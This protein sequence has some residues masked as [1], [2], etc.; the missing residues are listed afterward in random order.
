MKKFLPNTVGVVLFFSLFLSPVVQAQNFLINDIHAQEGILMRGMVSSSPESLYENPPIDPSPIDFFKEQISKDMLLSMYE[1]SGLCNSNVPFIVVDFSDDPGGTFHLS[2]DFRN[3]YCCG[4]SGGGNRCF[5]VLLI[6]SDQTAA[7]SIK[8]SGAPATGA[9]NWWLTPLPAQSGQCALPSY[10]IG[11]QACIAEGGIYAL[12]FCKPGQNT[13]N[14]IIEAIPYPQIEE[15]YEVRQDCSVQLNA[16]GFVDSSVTW[17]G[18]YLSALD[19]STGILTPTFTWSPGLPLYPDYIEYTICGT[20]LA[21]DECINQIGE[22]CATTRIYVYPE[23]EAG[24]TPVEPLFCEGGSILVEALASGGKP[25]YM[26]SW[27]NPLGQVVSSE[28]SINVSDAGEYTLVVSDQLTGAGCPAFEFDFVIEQVSLSLSA[29]VEA[30]SCFDGNDGSINVSVSGG[31]EPFQYIWS[32]DP[33]LNGPVASHLSAGQYSLTVTDANGCEAMILF[34]VGQPDSALDATISQIEHESCFGANDGAVGI[35]VEGGTPPYI[36]YITDEFGQTVSFDDQAVNQKTAGRNTLFGN[37]SSLER[38]KAKVLLM[39]GQFTAS[40]LAPGTYTVNVFDANA[41][42][43]EFTF[44]IEPGEQIIVSISADGDN[45]FCEGGSVELTASEGAT[46]LWSTGQPTQSIVVS[47]SGTYTV[48]VFSEIGC[49]GEASIEITVFELPDVFLADFDAVCED[50]E[51]FVLT[52]GLPAGGVY[53]GIGVTDGMFD[54]ALAG[55]GTFEITYSYTDENGCSNFAV[56]SI[57]LNELPAVSCPA[58]MA[59]SIGTEP[60]ELTGGLPSGG[61]Y[62]GSGVSGGIF[63]PAEAGLGQHTITYFFEDENGCEN[64]CTFVI[65]VQELPVVTCPDDIFVCADAEAFEVSGGLPEGGEFSGTG[66]IDDLFDP[67]LSGPG[68]FEITYTYSDEL[69]GLNTCVFN[70]TVYELPQVTLEAFENICEHGEAFELTGGL[71]AGGIYSG[72]GVVNGMFDPTLVGAGSYQITYTYTDQNGC[73]N[74]ATASIFVQTMF[75]FYDVVDASCFGASDGAIYL[76][77]HNGNGVYTFNWSNGATTQNLENIPAGVYSVEISDGNNCQLFVT[78]IVVSQP[79]EIVIQGTLTQLSYLGASD[80]SIVTL[81]SGGNPP[82]TYAWSNGQTTPDIHNL[83]AGAYVLTVTDADGCQTVAEFVIDEGAILVDLQVTIEVNIP[84]PDPDVVDELIFAVV[85]TNLNPLIDATGVSV[86]NI[87]P[88]VF[89]FIARLDAGTH[90]TYDP[91]TGIWTI[92]TVPAGQYALLV[93][94]TGMLLN[95]ENPTAINAA[96]ILPFDQED[97][98]LDNNYDE[99]VVTIGESSGGDDGGIESDGSMASKIALRFHRRLVEG[100]AIEQENRLKEMPAFA[101]S[102]MLTGAINTATLNGTPST[103][104]SYFIP[105]NGP[106]QTKAYVST[107]AD[108]LSITN[109]NEIFAVDYLQTN[110]ARRAAI[111]AIATNPGSVYEHTKVICDRLTGASLEDIRHIQI[112]G[113]P[114]ILSKLVHPNGYIDYSVSFIA[115]WRNNGFTIDNRWHNELYNPSGSEEVFNFQVWSVAPQFTR[116]LVES[117]LEAMSVAGPLNFRNA[118]ST[119]QIPKVYVQNGKYRNGKLLLN[120]INANGASK[121]SLYGSKAVVEN[122][123]R[124][125]FQIEVNIPTTAASFVEVNVGYLF[126]AGFSIANNLDNTRD[127]LYYAD[128]PWMFDYDPG[129]SVVTHFS[130]E[131]ETGLLHDRS[132]NIERDASIKGTVRSY[133]S[134]FRRLGPGKQPMDLTKYNQL[135]FHAS[136]VGVVEVMLAKASVNSWDKQF[137]TVITLDPAGKDYLI[138][139]SDLRTADGE[140]G[141]TADDLISVIFNPIG[142]GSNASAFEVNVSRLHFTSHLIE[143]NEAGIFYPNYPNPFKTTTSMEFVVTSD[144]QVKIEV[145][146]MLGQTMEVLRDETMQQGAYKVDWTPGNLRPGIYMFRITIG[147]QS[148]SGKMVYQP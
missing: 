124:E 97:P 23:I 2:D 75:A 137:R 103:G 60:F 34:M 20:V 16:M 98:N 47:E 4:I 145:L 13:Y 31:T 70:I 37:H 115:T 89:P 116:E 73:T 81:V 5:E 66:L 41:C 3:G 80:G 91:A 79:S 18:D 46:Y 67:A 51:A 125:W 61:S 113:Q 143:A 68:T 114:F 110:N 39:K 28:S 105:E 40:N 146:N 95:E 15:T 21:N 136:G 109:A 52:G 100:R 78:G 19:F 54:P 138:N 11:D 49:E 135:A 112:A 69:G 106:A 129:H 126:D 140:K 63:N 96:Q 64:F 107:P 102:E 26:F 123:D 88:D 141:F 29:T 76:E 33:A 104:I 82:Y 127:V 119:P 59:V 132:Y 121:I 27:I 94:R 14:L 25:P 118:I 131:P 8:L 142:N 56:A 74:F 84:T 72:P 139:F 36:L 128:G 48:T 130:T 62:S 32:H 1:P 7:V 42:E 57:T 6:L 111:L 101:I 77:V 144:S 45:E 147:N 108:L 24:I 92:G 22:F 122:G 30:V 120:L 65:T 148:Y 12:A 87:P 10:K 55:V 50:A 44:N 99:V 83:T 38:L 58:D 90:G 117:I 9:A 35:N 134:L 93:Y 53:S 43:H 85:V 86:E 133:A 71:P 17:S